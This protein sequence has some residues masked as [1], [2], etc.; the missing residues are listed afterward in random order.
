[1]CKWGTHTKV[2]LCK[3]DLKGLTKNQHKGRAKILD[4]KE[5]EELIDSCIAPLV[6]MLND[7]GIETI[8][9]CCGHG[10]VKISNIRIHPK[11][12]KLSIMKDTFTVWLEFPYK[13]E[14]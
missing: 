3:I 7:Y 4:M 13:E 9:S 2:K 12:I 10:K 5:N 14:S 1:M 6:Q 11:N 8:A